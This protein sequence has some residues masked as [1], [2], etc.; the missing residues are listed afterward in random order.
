MAARLRVSA[1][2]RAAAL[3]AS[4]LVGSGSVRWPWMMPG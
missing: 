3:M 2:V 4:A 1:T